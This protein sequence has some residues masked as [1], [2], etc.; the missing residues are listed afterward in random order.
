M[1][2]L[3]RQVEHRVLEGIG[4]IIDWVETQFDGSHHK[5]SWKPKDKTLNAITRFWQKEDRQDEKTK[6]QSIEEESSME[7]VNQTCATWQTF[8]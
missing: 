1:V 6:K 5:I 4:H 3:Q 2:E 8:P 7:N